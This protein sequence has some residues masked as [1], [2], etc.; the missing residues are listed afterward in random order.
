MLPYTPFVPLFM[1]LFAQFLWAYAI[2]KGRWPFETED[3]VEHSLPVRHHHSV[4]LVFA[5]C[6]HRY[7]L[8]RPWFKHTHLDLIENEIRQ[9]CLGYL[10]ESGFDEVNEA[11]ASYGLTEQKVGRCIQ[12]HFA[13]VMDAKHKTGDDIMA[14]EVRAHILSLMGS[15]RV[16]L[17]PMWSRGSWRVER[18][19]ALFKIRPA[20]YSAHQKMQ[21]L[22]RYRALCTS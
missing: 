20:N 16:R 21:A 2:T 4:A 17:S 11:H 12:P 19:T 10:L 13:L 14:P 6:F 1:V 3:C 8:K 5:E 7:V 9:L 22:G 15:T 18:V